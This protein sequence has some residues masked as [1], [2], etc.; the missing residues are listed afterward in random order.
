VTARRLLPALLA[1]V[2]LAALMAL[3]V[4]RGAPDGAEDGFELLAAAIIAVCVGAAALVA[5]PSWAVS[6]ALVLTLFQS[7]WDALGVSF[8]VDRYV[9][10]LVIG[11]VLVRE[12][13]H[14]DGRLATRPVDWLL[15]V[16]LIYAAT[17][18]WVVGELSTE[19]GRFELLDRFGVMPFVLFFLAPL[20]FRTE[21]DR[22]VLLGTLV[23][24][25]TY[26]GITAILETTGPKGVI[27]PSYITDPAQGIHQD[28]ARGPFLD[29]GANGLA[30]YMC[31]VAS[32][33]A[34]TKWRN[35][36]WR[37][38]ALLVAGLC[39]VGVLLTLT[40]AV[41]LGALVATP[42]ALLSA[43][44]A[45]RFLVPGMLAGL[46]LIVAAFAMIPGLQDR[47]E[48]RRGDKQPVW[49]RQNSNSAAIRMLEDRPLFGFG[50]SRFKE[51]S[52]P[53]YRQSNDFPLG[54]TGNLHNVYLSNAVDLG[55]VGL[56]LW[57]AALLAALG[58]AI[59]RRGP[60]EL[61]A[62]KV[63]L[64]AVTLSVL[65]TWATAPALFVLPTL[66]LWLW[67]GIAWGPRT[68]SEGAVDDRHAARELKH[69]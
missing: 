8:S 21:R 44:G 14:R 66:L 64:L 59:V 61:V 49:D 26:L 69:A 63:G 57:I 3:I 7:H 19:D 33:I 16:T 30:L 25:G 1:A 45:R 58:G 27:V 40:R 53:Y 37:I 4:S 46:V 6:G 29:A 20:V 32:T 22:R 28:R 17:S 60:P 50:W 31:A 55:L 48:R 23:A 12:W 42:V 67:A 15:A 56:A 39:L 35:P 68:P 11:S 38:F 2:P 41:W 43:R 9:M 47:A 13:R 18:A 52:P 5:P 62:W 34:F 36:R 65:I 10:L 24:I 54:E 51:E